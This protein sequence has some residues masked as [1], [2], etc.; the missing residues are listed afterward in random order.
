MKP[1]MQAAARVTTA[2]TD[3]WRYGERY[4]HR[5]G[6]DGSVS[7]E[8]VPLKKEDLLFPQEGDR[9][10]L[11]DD[12]SCDT[13]YL[14]GVLRSR[15]AKTPGRRVFTDH[16]I[17]FEVP[18]IEPLGPDVLVLDGVGEWDGSRGTFPVRSM[19]ATTLLGIEVTSPDSRRYDLG[20]KLDLYYRCAM[21]WYAIVDRQSGDGHQVRVLA[22]RASDER[23]VE[24]PPDNRGR[25]WLEPVGLWLGVAD[26]RATFYDKRGRKI[27]APEKQVA[28]ELAA[29]KKA[30]REKAALRKRTE[31]EKSE[32]QKRIEQLEGELRQ[33][34]GN[35]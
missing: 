15:A 8:I 24:V 32:L 19:G 30:E 16:R 26:R 7:Y 13:H 27:L 18:G 11:T 3:K 5:V 2:D 33:S 28:A 31:R 10:V 1:A 34:R 22:Y 6:P 29:R 17:D 4:L 9:P 14:F 23:Y 20:E 25:V 21:P 12:H 35:K